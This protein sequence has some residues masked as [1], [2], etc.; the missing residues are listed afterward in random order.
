MFSLL[1]LI[2]P[3]FVLIFVL[4]ADTAERMSVKSLPTVLVSSPIFAVLVEMS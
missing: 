3:E 1:V 2:A 4:L